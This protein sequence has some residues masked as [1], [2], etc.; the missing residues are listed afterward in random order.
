MM[1]FTIG[2]VFLIVAVGIALTA[3]W[4]DFRSLKIS[5][6]LSVAMFLLFWPAYFL[7]PDLFA[8]FVSHIISGVIV[9]LVTFLMFAA[10]MFG[11]G[12]AKMASAMALW[13]GI[14]NMSAFIM[15]MAL[16]GGILALVGFAI[17]KTGKI[18]VKNEASW[19][20]QLQ[21]GRNAIPYGIALCIGYVF[22]IV[23][24]Y[25]INSVL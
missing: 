11:G 17:K 12:D 24:F 25:F 16:A 6:K 18:D 20:F 13:F 22:C 4:Q 10:N 21:N 5:N 15:V 9:F 2:H 19:L 3:A 8:P 23:N 7:Q 14:K 1:I